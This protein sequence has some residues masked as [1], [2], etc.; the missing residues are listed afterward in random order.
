VHRIRIGNA[1]VHCRPRRRHRRRRGILFSVGDSHAIGRTHRYPARALSLFQTSV[2]VGL[3]AS[4]WLGGAVASRWG[5]RAVFWIFGAGG[6]ALSVPMRARLRDKPVAGA[7]SRAAIG[8]TLRAILSTPTARFAA[9]ACSDG[10]RQC[11]LPG[12]DAELSLR[13]NFI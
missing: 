12:L 13:K 11:R 9:L 7:A 5:W 1:L 10:L 2:Y 6:L 3:V 8:Q 4:G